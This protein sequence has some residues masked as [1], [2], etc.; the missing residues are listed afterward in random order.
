MIPHD[1]KEFQAIFIGVMM[2]ALGGFAAFLQGHEGKD[3]KPM[4][5]IKALLAK[6]VIA[7]FL[8][9]VVGLLCQS[10]HLGVKE[11]C[12][13]ASMA[14]FFNKEALEL[15]KEWFKKRMPQ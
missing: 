12:V 7:V 8:G 9:A 10:M 1:N 4:D 14:G 15:L 5:F 2:A 6:L 3:L 13:M 11:S